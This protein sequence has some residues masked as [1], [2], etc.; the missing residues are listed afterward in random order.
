MNNRSEFR[1]LA[2]TISHRADSI[3]K[4][5]ICDERVPEAVALLV[6]NVELLQSMLAVDKSE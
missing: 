2:A 4:G 1:A 6:A 5:R 3:A